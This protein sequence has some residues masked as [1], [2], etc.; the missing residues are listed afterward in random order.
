MHEDPTVYSKAECASLLRQIDAGNQPHGGLQ[1]VCQAYGLLGCFKFL[2]VGDAGSG[3]GC[4]F[5][6]TCS[7]LRLSTPAPSSLDL[8]SSRHRVGLLAHRAS[9][10]SW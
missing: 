1:L 10:Y 9:T 6:P 8:A 4:C 2:E 3:A 7:G 5:K